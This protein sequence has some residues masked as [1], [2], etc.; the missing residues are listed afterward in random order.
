[1]VPEIPSPDSPAVETSPASC[2]PTLFGE[3]YGTY[4]TKRSAFACSYAANALMVALAL[5]AGHWL[6]GH[7]EQI[8]LQ[9]TGMVTNISPYIL[10]PAPKEAGGGGGG[11][12]RDKLDATKGSPPRFANEQITP[13]LVVVRKEQPLLT[14]EPTVIGP[15]DVQ[16]PQS[17]Q[18]GDPLG[19]VMASLSNG[20]G[21]GGGIGDGNGGGVGS[22]NGRGVGPGQGAGIGDGPY[23]PGRGG[24]TPPRT[25][26]APDP[27]YSDEARHAK[28]QGS[29]LLWLVVGRDGLPKDVRIVRSV[30]LGLDERALAAVRSWRFDPGR[31]DG[32]P[33]ATQINVEVSFRLY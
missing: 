30:G 8:R 1:M 21:S 2:L 11:G 10:P 26:Y 16:L 18:M 25:L 29:V 32:Q 27:D 31:K 3:G 33:V 15:P 4:R 14:A 7:G 12:D 13:P 6:A 9:V 22:G 24:V 19:V 20:R 17:G 28:F 23:R 5:W